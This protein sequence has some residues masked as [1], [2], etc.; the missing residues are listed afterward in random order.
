VPQVDV[1]GQT[2][3]VYGQTVLVPQVSG[4][5]YGVACVKPIA[6]KEPGY[7]NCLS[8]DIQ[9][10]SVDIDCLS[11][12]VTVPQRLRHPKWVQQRRCRR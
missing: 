11:V 10:L 8:V 4:A 6:V 3:N 12:D 7:K 5:F 2:P 1:Y 9:R